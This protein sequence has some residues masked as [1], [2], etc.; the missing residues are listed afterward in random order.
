ML[1][2]ESIAVYFVMKSMSSFC[3]GHALELV[4]ILLQVLAKGAEEANKT[5]NLTLENCRQA[6]GFTPKYAART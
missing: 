6:M 2:F 4:G 3:R 5:A 1:A